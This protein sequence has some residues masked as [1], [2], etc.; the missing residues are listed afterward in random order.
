MRTDPEYAKK[1]KEKSEFIK[2]FV[3]PEKSIELFLVAVLDAIK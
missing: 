1:H 3:G 2:N